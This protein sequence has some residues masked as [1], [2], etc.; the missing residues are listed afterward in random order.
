MLRRGIKGER[1]TQ[2]K[3]SSDT[4][5]SHSR[6]RVL[7]SCRARDEIKQKIKG[8]TD[9]GAEKRQTGKFSGLGA[10]LGRKMPLHS[11][12]FL[13]H[14]TMSNCNTAVRGSFTGKYWHIL[15]QL[16]ARPLSSSSLPLSSATH[17]GLVIH[18]SWSSVSK[19]N[20]RCDKKHISINCVQRAWLYAD[21]FSTSFLC[22]T[23]AGYQIHNTRAVC[24]KGRAANRLNWERSCQSSDKECK[25][26]TAHGIRQE[27]V[28]ID[29]L[30]NM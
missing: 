6:C 29:S 13:L 3:Q 8:W 7:I 27:R 19:F 18:D 24:T 22:L 10:E 17:L 14:I 5:M 21:R 30:Y 4:H 11:R 23:C 28:G 26:K 12:L 1:E 20:L 16:S 9:D 15:S 2:N 25:N